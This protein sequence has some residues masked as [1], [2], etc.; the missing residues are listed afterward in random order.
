MKTAY[1][2]PITNNLI[3]ISGEIFESGKAFVKSAVVTSNG[4]RMPLCLELFPAWI[5]AEM[6]NKLIEQASLDAQK[7]KS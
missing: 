1:T 6:Q 4:K 7:N 3:E 2:S 5:I